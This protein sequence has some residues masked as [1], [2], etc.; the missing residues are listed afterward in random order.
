MKNCPRCNIKIG[1]RFQYCP[2][3][4]NELSGD[5]TEQYFPAVRQLRK[6]NFWYKLQL[7]ISLALVIVSI[8]LDFM[9]EIHSRIHW[10]I[11]AAVTAVI[12]QFVMR[13]LINKH[14]VSIH[15]YIYHITLASALVNLVFSYYLDYL[16]FSVS[17]IFPS[18]LILLVGSMFAFGITDKSGK[19]MVYLLTVIGWGIII[20]LLVLTLV[21]PKFEILW[22]ICLMLTSVVLTGTLVFKGS[23]VLNELHKR[24][25]M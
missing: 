11:I 8:F 9:L 22:Q 18:L 17:Y 23:K 1:G 2:L 14:S 5:E 4:Q 6:K 13:R 12:V 7:F 25:H 24:L 19:V 21:H 10:S 20:P 15:Y 16:C 3:C